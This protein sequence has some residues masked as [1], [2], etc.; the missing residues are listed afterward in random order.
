M[1]DA[2]ITENPVVP[3]KPYKPPGHLLD[4]AQR[5]LQAR[6][7]PQVSGTQVLSDT[8]VPYTL[9]QHKLSSA[10][11]YIKDRQ[12]M[13]T[14]GLISSHVTPR[15]SGYHAQVGTPHPNLITSPTWRRGLGGKSKK[16]MKI[17][18]PANYTILS[19]PANYT[20]PVTLVPSYVPSYQPIVSTH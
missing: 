1:P 13:N 6:R 3:A 5:W 15:I 14:Q 7:K 9:P 8:A 18:P 10:A 20:T 17:Q 4:D 2:T 16:C 11:Q 12:R 19:W